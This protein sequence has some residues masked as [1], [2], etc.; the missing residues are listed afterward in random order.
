MSAGFLTT[1]QEW[2]ALRY[3]DHLARDLYLSLRRDMNFKT[4][5][6]GGP[7]KGISWQSLREDTEVPGRPGFKGIKPSEQQLRRRAQQLEQFGLVRAISGKLRLKFRLL[8]AYTDTHAQ[9]KAGG[10]AIALKG[11][12]KARP[13]KRS[14]GYAQGNNGPKADTHQESGKTYTLPNPSRGSEAG[15][16][17]L[18]LPPHADGAGGEQDPQLQPAPVRQLAADDN[19]EAGADETGID[20]APH[21][22][23]AGGEQAPPT[24]PTEAQRLSEER[25]QTIQGGGDGPSARLA[26]GQG[27]EWKDDL[28][29][30]VSISKAQRASMAIDLKAV[31]KVQGQRVLDEL[32]GAMQANIVKDPWAYFHGL[33]RNAQEQGDAWKTVYADKIALARI[34]YRQTLAEQAARDAAFAATLPKQV[35]PST[36]LAM[37]KARNRGRH[38]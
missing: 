9:N 24:A 1:D 31:S 13:D 30:P 14:K 18:N 38:K 5:I 17:D 27:F 15:G 12:R 22:D 20:P 2:R 11:D 33:L 3:V 37:T 28:D 26:R 34:K 21:A 36:A 19:P 6:V 23:G 7:E 16:E 25:Q 29:W 32:R 4:G 35:G 10:S 8:L